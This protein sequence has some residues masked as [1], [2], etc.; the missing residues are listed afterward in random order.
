MDFCSNIFNYSELM[1][2]IVFQ[3]KLN[4]TSS[5]NFMEQKLLDNF[6]NDGNS[7]R[8]TVLLVNGKYIFLL[9]ILMVLMLRFRLKLFKQQDQQH[10]EQ[11]DCLGIL[12][13][14][15]CFIAFMLLLPMLVM[16]WLC[17]L[18]YRQY[19]YFIIRVS[20]KLKPRESKLILIWKYEY[21]F[22]ISMLAFVRKNIADE[23]VVSWKVQ[24]PFGHLKRILLKV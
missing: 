21:F 14:F 9:A 5:P 17:V 22:C 19:I 23:F 8:N 1:S 16:T 13:S 10:W 15:S 3:R 24:M 6:G 11:C 12:F 2:T 18:C 20:C 4:G 7:I